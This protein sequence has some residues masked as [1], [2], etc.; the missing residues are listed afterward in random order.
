SQLQMIANASKLLDLCDLLPIDPTTLSDVAGLPYDSGGENREALPATCL[1]VRQ[2]PLDVR[3]QVVIAEA[4]RELDPCRAD[5]L[6]EA[7]RV[8]QRRFRIGRMANPPSISKGQQVLEN[9]LRNFTQDS[10]D[11]EREVRERLHG[12]AQPAELVRPSW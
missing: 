4:V 6:N 2:A 1:E 7:R 12:F 8:V 11:P 3:F 10:A 5:R 9:G